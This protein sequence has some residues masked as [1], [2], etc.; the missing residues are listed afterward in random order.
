MA[1]YGEASLPQQSAQNISDANQPSMAAASMPQ[2]S[3]KKLKIPQK[4]LLVFFRQL[5]VV[6]QSGVS[7]AQGL[8][9]IGE[10]MTNKKFRACIYA[11]AARLNAGDAL[12]IP[13]GW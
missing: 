1:E 4:D 7:L 2:I 9:L 11:I 6:L 5:A 3:P 10:N 8:V 13:D 12:L